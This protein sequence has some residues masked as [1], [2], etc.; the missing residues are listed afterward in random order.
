MILFYV[1]CKEGKEENKKATSISGSFA[2]LYV[3]APPEKYT[4]GSDF[5]E[6]DG[7]K[8]TLI[9]KSENQIEIDGNSSFFKMDGEGLEL[10]S[11]LG[12]PGFL[13]IPYPGDS[14]FEKLKKSF[15]EQ[16]QS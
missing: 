1:G 9:Y 12:K 7:V 6:V 10:S 15:E 8:K 16:P 11:E 2:C 13:C 4:F 5:V 14:E 3:S